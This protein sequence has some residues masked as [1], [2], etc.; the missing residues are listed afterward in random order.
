[1]KKRK[2]CKKDNNKTLKIV[3]GS[4]IGIMALGVAAALLVKF[5]V[6]NIQKQEYTSTSDIVSILENDETKALLDEAKLKKEN[7]DYDYLIDNYSKENTMLYSSLDDKYNIVLNLKNE[8]ISYENSL[9]SIRFYLYE[10]KINADKYLQA[11]GEGNYFDASYLTKAEHDEALASLNSDKDMCTEAYFDV[12]ISQHMINK[13]EI[14][15]VYE[16]VSFNDLDITKV[17]HTY[18]T[19]VDE[20]S[21]IKTGIQYYIHG[22]FNIQDKFH[23]KK[24]TYDTLS[25]KIEFTE[26]LNNRLAI[27]E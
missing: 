2:K 11:S 27:D 18:E 10:E 4:L 26:I 16:T 13:D 12:M 24:D 8:V 21:V 6:F 20:Q 7:V 9:D 23:I 5:D 15:D 19:I 17:V 1:M 25:K 3:T 14:I 22:N